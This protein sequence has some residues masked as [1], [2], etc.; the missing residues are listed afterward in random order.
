MPA[1]LVWSRQSNKKRKKAKNSLIW[2]E[3]EEER[4]RK[5][6]SKSDGRQNLWNV[7]G[8]PFECSK[9]SEDEEVAASRC[10]PR[11]SC[12]VLPWDAHG[13]EP[14]SSSGMF[15]VCWSDNLGSRR[16]IKTN[17]AAR[18]AENA[19]PRRRRRETTGTMRSRGAG[20][21]RARVCACVN[22]SLCDWCDR[23][24]NKGPL[25]VFV[26]A[27]SPWAVSVT[28]IPMTLPVTLRP[29]LST[30]GKKMKLIFQC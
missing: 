28:L 2:F 12:A 22:P 18:R 11:V 30:S 16:R 27:H 1:L 26:K 6:K 4:E 9:K 15:R 13:R 25:S 24:K 23:C 7:K 19:R 8:A 10:S 20:L 21:M 29:H 5:K 17:C 3:K 14:Q